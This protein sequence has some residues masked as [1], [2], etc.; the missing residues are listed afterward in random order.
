MGVLDD[1]LDAYLF[2]VEVVPKWSKDSVPMLTI[3]NLHLS[4]LK[5]VNL[6]Y[7]EQSQHYSM[8]V[9]RLYWKKGKDLL[10]RLFIDKE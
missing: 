7:I 8:V 3:G 1:I 5:E 9:G 10:M 2:S 4:T 6:A